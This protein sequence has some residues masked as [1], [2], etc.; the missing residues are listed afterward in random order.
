MLNVFSEDGPDAKFFNL[1]TVRTVK[2]IDYATIYELDPI[3]DSVQKAY[4]NH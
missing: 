4:P 2:Q 1:N 3:L